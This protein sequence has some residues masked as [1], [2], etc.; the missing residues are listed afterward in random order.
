MAGLALPRLPAFQ[1]ARG[2]IEASTAE[3]STQ[4]LHYNLL[5]F[6]SIAQKLGVNLIKVTWQ[7]GLD[8][9]GRGASSTVQ[10]ALIDKRLH[11]AFKRSVSSNDDFSMDT[12]KLEKERFQALILEMI[13]LEI[14]RENP[15]VIDLLGVT[16]ETSANTHQVWPV[17]L[18]E[19]SGMGTMEQF[20]ASDEGRQLDGM[21]KLRLCI[22]IADACEAMHSLG[23]LYNSLCL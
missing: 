10:Q 22:Q 8:R 2:L 4:D 17:L 7:P 6:F 13:A 1:S 16:Y 5:S 19:R 23:M 21:A 20:L 14:L 18:M 3:V 9:L 12:E 11:M 15:H